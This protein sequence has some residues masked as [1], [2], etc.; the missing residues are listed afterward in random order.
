[1]QPV[2]TPPAVDLGGLSPLVVITLAAVV[3]TLAGAFGAGGRLVA[4]LS[5]G[6]LGATALATLS[7]AGQS[8]RLFGETFVVDRFFVFFALTALGVTALTVLASLDRLAGGSEATAG[9]YYGLLLFSTAGALVLAGANDL[10]LVLLGLELLSLA[11]YVLAGFRR[12]APTSQEAAMKYFLLGAFSLGF[13]I[14]GTALVY[15]A[16]GTTAFSG[17]ASAV[18]SRGLLTDPLLLAGLGLL[19]V[20]FAFKLSLVPFH[21]WTP[22]VYEGA[23]TAIAGFM[24]VGTKVAV[25]AALLR[26]VGAALPGVRGDWTAV[27]WALAVLTLIVGNVAA[28]VQTSL[29]RLLAYSSIAQAGYILIAVVAGPAGQ[30]AVLFYLL[31][32]VFMN[33]GAFGALLALGPAGEEAPHLAD[34]AGLARRSPWVGAVL[35]LSLLSLAGI[36]PTAGFVAKLYVFSAAIQAGYLDLV[37]LGVLTSAVAAFYYLRVLAALYAEGGEPAPVRVPASLGVVLG[38]TGVLT[39][40]LG[41]APAIQWAEGTLALALP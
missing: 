28:V 7:L 5:L 32:Y 13:M 18:T 33:L 12:T 27:L 22:D 20:G 11:L 14:Y 25:F 36:P 6:G 4:L 37:A 15:G 10:L 1:M 31:A 26:W 35:T 40:V 34:V 3:V 30:G 24:S 41:V 9:D 38:V 16:T 8:R 17:I 2:F 39:L 29:K 23:P 21:M 19:V